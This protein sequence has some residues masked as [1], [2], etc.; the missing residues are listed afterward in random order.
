[1]ETGD[2][3]K[4]TLKRAGFILCLSLSLTGNKFT[5]EQS[6]I[7]VI[8][9]LRIVLV[10]WRRTN[11]LLCQLL[12]MLL[13]FVVVVVY[14]IFAINNNLHNNF[15]LLFLP[16]YSIPIPS[17]L[18]KFSRI[19]RICWRM[20][21]SNFL[22]GR[23]KCV[24]FYMCWFIQIFC[25]VLIAL[26]SHYELHSCLGFT[27]WNWYLLLNAGKNEHTHFCCFCSLCF[28]LMLKELVHLNDACF[29]HNWLRTTIT[30]TITTSQPASQPTVNQQWM[31][32]SFSKPSNKYDKRW[33]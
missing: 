28:P 33:E 11:G 26:H 10:W 15:I 29:H 31:F 17:F 3:Q 1:M 20:I 13:L 5:N 18:W 23:R 25:F 7:I 6:I 21:H 16:C 32:S 12:L 19:Y 2:K 9:L 22:I 4:Q 27:I 30:I 8:R 14:S 24:F